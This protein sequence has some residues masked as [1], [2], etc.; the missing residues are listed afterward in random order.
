MDDL[1]QPPQDFTAHQVVLD[2]YLQMTRITEQGEC[3]SDEV[4][5]FAL[6][7]A[8]TDI[9]LRLDSL[10]TAVRGESARTSPFPST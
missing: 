5:K 6:W 4:E 10:T 9:A 7:M 8:L 3:D 1:H 2:L